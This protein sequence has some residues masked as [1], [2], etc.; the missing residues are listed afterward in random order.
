M[1]IALKYAA[2]LESTSS[3]L[4]ATFAVAFACIQEESALLV[5]LFRETFEPQQFSERERR[6]RTESA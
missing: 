1:E 6:E 2:F 4:T 3:D 5:Y